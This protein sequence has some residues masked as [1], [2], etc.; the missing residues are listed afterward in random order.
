MPNCRND[1]RVRASRK[2]SEQDSVTA[3]RTYF[4]V[5]AGPQ[6]SVVSSNPAAWAAVIS[7]LISLTTSATV[8]AAFARQECT[9]PAGTCAPVTSLIS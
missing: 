1:S 5:P 8:P 4:L 9:N 7:V 6:R 2:N 3:A